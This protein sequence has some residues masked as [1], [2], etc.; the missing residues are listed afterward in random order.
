V[1]KSGSSSGSNAKAKAKT[2][3]GNG[4]RRIL[5]G[6]SGICRCVLFRSAPAPAAGVVGG[7][8]VDQLIQGLSH[9]KKNTSRT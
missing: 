3:A 4:E 1:P 9:H 7:R 2:K 5:K 6:V 8:G